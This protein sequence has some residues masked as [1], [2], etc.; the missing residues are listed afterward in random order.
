MRNLISSCFEKTDKVYIENLEMFEVESD[1]YA[2]NFK[3][4]DVLHTQ[5]RTYFD[6]IIQSFNSSGQTPSRDLFCKMFPE[7]KTVLED[8]SIVE[9]SLN[10]LK[11]Y[12]FNLVDLRVNDYISKR[13]DELNKKVKNVGITEA[14][15]DEFQRLQKLSNRNKAKDINIRIDGRANY[16]EL[17]LR[18]S[19]MET[20]IKD[21][22]DKIG[23]MD[24]G[25]V[26][27]IA[28]FTSQFKTTFALNIAHR[29]AYKN[30]YNIVYISLETKKEDMYWNLLSRHSYESHL[31]KWDY[32]KHD[33]IRRCLLTPE[34]EDYVFNEVE[35]DLYSPYEYEGE[36]F[37]RGQVI[38]LDES[39]FESF[40]FGEIT[41]VLEEI[42]KKLNGHL[43]C[44]IVDYIQLCKF[45]G[46]GVVSNE[47]SQVNAYVSFFRR[48]S[49]Y[50]KK[51]T[52]QDGTVTTRQLIV[53]LLSQIRRDSWR[54][55]VNKNGI[56]D[57]TCMSDASELEKSAF[58]IFTT[59]TTEEMKGRNI[60][61]VQILKNRSGLTMI[62]EPSTVFVEG[63]AY[64]FCDDS[65]DRMR[66]NSFQS[67]GINLGDDLNSV[68]DGVDFVDS[69]VSDILG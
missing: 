62:N 25:T 14:I 40:S 21:I 46:E 3:V 66:S 39:D 19:G 4:P 38:I 17:K 43:D 44:V 48:L 35:K 59:Y 54:R 31:S 51:E 50:F 10:D 27:V 68:M 1:N 23:G 52:H 55:A 6:F 24:E 34:Q 58:R 2:R 57:I 29:N 63:E 47:T 65:D 20:G 67:S 41:A 45:S 11:V 22:D 32:I 18:P 33:S 26:T 42:D 69:S 53:I 16:E 13:L 56:Y 37:P 49:Q 60:A 30:N 12:I 9:I 36:M 15:A 5:E 8:P 28:G 64:V 61:Q 7:T